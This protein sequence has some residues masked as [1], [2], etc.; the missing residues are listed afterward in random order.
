[1]LYQLILTDTELSYE[2]HCADFAIG[3][4]ETA[5]QA[6]EVALHYLKHVPGFCQ[7]PCTWRIQPMEVYGAASEAVW[8][9][10]GWNVNQWLDETDI[11]ESGCFAEKA[12][13]EE[14]RKA[15]QAATPRAEWA[16]IRWVIG[17]QEWQEGFRRESE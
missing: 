8:V 1:M 15:M 6:R 2:T 17:K 14:A 5:Q 11:V 7:Y 13:A 3:I 16:V 9:V 12:Q 4:F 10:Q